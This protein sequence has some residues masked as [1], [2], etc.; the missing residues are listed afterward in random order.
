[1]SYLISKVLNVT[2]IKVNRKS[3]MSE[4]VLNESVTMARTSSFIETCEVCC[5]VASKNNSMKG[6]M[7]C[8]IPGAEISPD[9][10][11]ES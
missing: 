7:F 10:V 3:V 1:M 9:W 11:V 5:S 4:W 2:S 8:H 6:A